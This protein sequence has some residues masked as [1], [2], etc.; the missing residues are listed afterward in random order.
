MEMKKEIFVLLISLFFLQLVACEKGSIEKD[1]SRN[2][3][4]PPAIDTSIHV[5]PTP[6]IQTSDTVNIKQR[7][8]IVFSLE[9]AGSK[10]IQWKAAPAAKIDSRGI[11]A[12]FT[13]QQSG[14][15]RIYAID[16]LEGD[17]IIKVHCGA[18][19]ALSGWCRT[20]T[21]GKFRANIAGLQTRRAAKSG[22]IVQAILSCIVCAMQEFF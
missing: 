11:W 13:F 21:F 16:S 3:A 14:P 12:Y 20:I 5:K 22:K 9:N 15:H 7:N 19:R 1:L 10:P 6:F 18:V 2:A 17:T 4:L 8:L